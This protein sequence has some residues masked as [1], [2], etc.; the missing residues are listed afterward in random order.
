MKRFMMTMMLV[1]AL[2][3]ATFSQDAFYIYRN[4]GQ[5]NAFFFEDVDSMAYSKYDV[6]SLFHEEYVVQEVFTSD[7]TYRIPLA[8]IDSIGF[9]TPTTIYKPDVLHLSGEIYDY[10]LTASADNMRVIFSS[11]IPS[12]LLPV[13]GEKIAA[14]ELTDKNPSGFAGKVVKIERINNQ[15]YLECEQI[16]LEEAVSRFYGVAN[17]VSEYGEIVDKEY[18]PKRKL[19]SSK[20][21]PF[22]I[23]LPPRLHLPID[24]EKAGFFKKERVFETDGQAKITLDCIEPKVTGTISY[25]INLPLQ[26]SYM[27]MRLTTSANFTANIAIGGKI[28]KGLNGAFE[29]DFPIWGVPLFYFAIGIKCNAEAELATDFTLYANFKDLTFDITDYPLLPRVATINP[30]IIPVRC[31]GVSFPLPEWNSF[32]VKGEISFA[33]PYMDLGICFAKHEIGWAGIEV[34]TGY[35]ADADIS[36]KAENLSQAGINTLFYD[37]LKDSKIGLETYFDAKAVFRLAKSGTDPWDDYKYNYG[38]SFLDIF[39][40]D[41]T[42]CREE[43]WFLPQFRGT[44]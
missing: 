36:F 23:E 26:L 39:G 8:I 20:T 37:L 22:N 5:F 1:V 40:L 41:K 43:F 25:I 17:I 3:T 42:L 6:D 35:K 12:E 9:V 10:L 19:W 29:E 33:I 34:E 28:G 38:T 14:L 31:N 11:D 4:D 27:H 16:M 7:S 2:A 15:I 21:A 13:V 44:E 18:I 24:I 30:R 32:A